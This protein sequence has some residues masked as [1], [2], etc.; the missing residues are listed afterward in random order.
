MVPHRTPT[1]GPMAASRLI[2]T[3][4]AFTSTC[5][6]VVPSIPSVRSSHAASRRAVVFL[7]PLLQELDRSGQLVEAV[8]PIFDG[9]PSREVHRLEEAKD[10]VVVVRPASRFAVTQ[11]VGITDG[12]V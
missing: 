10:G 1:T 5:G 2:R 8:H 12:P 3:G 4:K 9:N 11:L 6:A 7:A